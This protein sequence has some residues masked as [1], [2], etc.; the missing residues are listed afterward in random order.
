MP[1]LINAFKASD[2]LFKLTKSESKKYIVHFYFRNTMG[3]NQI[4]SEE[5]TFIAFV[6]S[7]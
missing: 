4:K 7:K 2:Y 1:N 5:K 6:E 3:M